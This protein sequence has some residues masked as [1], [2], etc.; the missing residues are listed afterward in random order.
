MRIRTHKA[1]A[2]QVGRIQSVQRDS[3][4]TVHRDKAIQS[5]VLGLPKTPLIVV[6]KPTAT[7]Q[8]A[9]QSAV[10]MGTSSSPTGY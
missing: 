9:I 6:S 8:P 2:G 3:T 4:L 10:V 1:P 7:K 5:A